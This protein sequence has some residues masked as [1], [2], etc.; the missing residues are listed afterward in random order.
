M[1]IDRAN[2]T[3]AIPGLQSQQPQATLRKRGLMGLGAAH[4]LGQD[5]PVPSDANSWQEIVGGVNSEL[6]YLINIDRL[7]S[8]KTPIPAEHAAPSV[9]V[10]LTPETRNIALLAGAGILALFLFARR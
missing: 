1:L 6:L 8:G 10:G 5:A 4:G 3:S 7:T 9:N 2:N